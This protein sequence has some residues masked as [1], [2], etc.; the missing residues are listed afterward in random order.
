MALEKVSTSW[1][2]EEVHGKIPMEIPE[3]LVMF[4]DVG[5]DMTWETFIEFFIMS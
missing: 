3:K 5:V 2:Q 4:R 1:M